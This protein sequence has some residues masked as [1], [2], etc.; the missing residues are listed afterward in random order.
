MKTL[1]AAALLA[2]AAPPAAARGAAVSIREDDGTGRY[3]VSG[4]FTVAATT[5]EAWRVLTDYD[6]IAAF[7]SSIRKSRVVRRDPEA[8]LV[9]QEG[10]GRFL[11]VSR[12]FKVTLLVTERPGRIDFRDVEGRQFRAYEGS[13]TIETGDGGC[14]VAYALTAQPDPSMGP[15]F[16]AKR[17]LRRS[18]ERLL[19][20]VRLEIERRARV[21]GGGSDG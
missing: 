12:G 4:A 2:W 18:A 19:D 11:F 3:D 5:D 8:L 20:E 7:V 9:E 14:K 13:W 17:A 6:G 15:R 1:L 21:R 10:T 16:A